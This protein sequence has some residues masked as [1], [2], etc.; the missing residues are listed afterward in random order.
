MDLAGRTLLPGFQDAH[1]HPVMAG[2]GLLQCPLHDLP[3]DAA[4]VPRDDRRPT[5][6]RIPTWPGSS[7]DGW[8]MAAFPGGTPRREDLDRVVPDRPAFFVNRDGHGAWVNSRALALAGIDRDTPDPPDGRI[9][10]D[11]DGDAHA[12]RSTKARWTSSAGSSRRRRPEDLVSGLGLAQAYLHR[13]GITAWQDAWV[14]ARPSSRPTAL[15]AERGLLTGRAIACQWWERERGGEQ[16]EEMI[17]ARRIST[18]GRLRA[19][20][21]KIM[22]DGVIENFTAAMLE[23]Y[24]GPDGRPTTNRGISFVDPTR[25]QAARHPARRRRVPGP[26]PCPGRPRGP[27]GARRD[28]GGAGGQR[29][30]RRTPPP[31][32]PPGGRPGRHAALPRARRGRQH[33]AA[34][35]PVAMPR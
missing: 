19:T 25:A 2:I 14:T 8:Y 35:G 11:P 18:I 6:P 33:P 13:L 29:T 12:E 22:Q 28:R 16:I 23:P 20:T 15:F 1:V 9:E 3:T 24:L 32:P 21:V 27:R 7:G 4:D 34:T 17:E 5:R 31:R 30:D 10:R 26:L